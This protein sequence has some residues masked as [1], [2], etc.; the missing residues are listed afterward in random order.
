MKLHELLG[1]MICIIS[2]NLLMYLLGFAKNALFFI[3]FSTI[4]ALVL[5]LTSTVVYKDLRKGLAVTYLFLGFVF[6]YAYGSTPGTSFSYYLGPYL[7]SII[8][9]STSLLASFLTLRS[10]RE[11]SFAYVLIVLSIPTALLDPHGL[12]PVSVLIPHTLF[13]R[14]A[15]DGL[16]FIT[17]SLLLY[18]PYLTLPILVIGFERFPQLNLCNVSY[19]SSGNVL[20]TFTAIA[21]V[22]T[23]FLFFDILY[24]RMIKYYLPRITERRHIIRNSFTFYLISIVVLVAVVVITYSFLPTKADMHYLNLIYAT[25]PSF[26]ISVLANSWTLIRET[27]SIRINIIKSL[28]QVKEELNICKSV[29][30]EL[31][32]NTL[33]GVKVSKYYESLDSTQ[34]ELNN[35]ES[36]LSRPSLS[37]SRLKKTVNDLEN[38]Q[39]RLNDVKKGVVDI[40]RSTLKEVEEIY[41]DLVTLGGFRNAE[42][43]ELIRLMRSINRFEDI[44]SVSIGFSRALSK[45]CES[46]IRSIDD[47]ITNINEIT[48]VKVDVN[49]S[50]KCSEEVLL[51][52]TSRAYRDMLKSL[53]SNENVNFVV[54]DL[55]KRTSHIK[56]FID[57]LIDEYRGRLHEG[58]LLLFERLSKTLSSFPTSVVSSR[59]FAEV[60]IKCRDLRGNLQEFVEFVTNEL[61]SEEKMIA[62]AANNLGFD[63]NVLVP[64]SAPTIGKSLRDL[65]GFQSVL[66]CDGLINWLNTKGLG[67][68]YEQIFYVEMYVKV[69]QSI[70]YIQLLKNYFDNLLEKGDVLL[71]NIPLSKDTLK[72]FINIY[73]STRNDVVL[74]GNVLRVVRR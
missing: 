48:G 45:I 73:I 54:S 69:L 53:L 55:I 17:M 49:T 65:N 14:T 30:S 41:N 56:E 28:H 47:L 71:D 23:T 29:L 32:I 10:S 44:P 37:L 22:L 57:K 40:Y 25:V 67:L 74:E 62:I 70:P 5:S 50:I 7:M 15:F 66:T 36:Y 61:M 21:I 20:D 68:I 4:Y 13:L 64:V 35:I 63:Y 72:W 26:L 31:S 2:I 8:P 11:I 16:W 43:D 27:D 58:F 1:L 39:K 19:S 6:I 33:L 34:K 46:F 9:L 52:D 12:L 38:I 18:A 42:L 3:T 60:K 24:H 59:D 51:I